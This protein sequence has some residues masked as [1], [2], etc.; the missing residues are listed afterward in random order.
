MTP[1]GPLDA[2]C[3]CGKVRV[4]VAMRPDYLNECNC[5]LCNSHGVWWGYYAPADVRIEGET[6]V[7]QRADRPDPAVRLHFCGTCGC[8]THWTMLP[9]F[10]EKTGEASRMGVN[11]RLFDIAQLT[12]IELRFPDGKAWDGK[13]QWGFV[14]E[15]VPL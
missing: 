11:M 9:A 5:S 1:E 3:H 4:R 10:I 15:P 6:R 8:T 14:R 2:S 7:Y 13:G 12:G